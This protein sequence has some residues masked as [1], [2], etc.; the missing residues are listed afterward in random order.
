MAN[1]HYDKGHRAGI[2]VGYNKAMAEI[3]PAIED[4]RRAVKALDDSLRSAHEQT[5]PAGMAAPTATPVPAWGTEARISAEF[6][7]LNVLALYPRS[8]YERMCVIA[9]YRHRTGHM[10]KTVK[11]LIEGGLISRQGSDDK[12][13]YSITMRGEERLGDPVRVDGNGIAAMW[14]GILLDG[15]EQ[16]VFGALADSHP[17]TWVTAELEEH[18]NFRRHSKRMR[19]AIKTLRAIGLISEDGLLGLSDHILVPGL[20]K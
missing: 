7:L 20:F 3:R 9:G 16:R 12:T 5:L 13:R 1:E 10:R 4:I 2:L 11:K 18:L 8:T 17:Y 14:E 19:A 6:A 15:P